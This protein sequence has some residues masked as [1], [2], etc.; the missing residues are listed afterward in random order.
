MIKNILEEADRLNDVL[1]ILNNII[2][3]LDSAPYPDYAFLDN[4][5]ITRWKV[6]GN[7]VKKA[8]NDVIQLIYDENHPVENDDD[9]LNLHEYV[10]SHT[11]DLLHNYAISI[12]HRVRPKIDIDDIRSWL[13]LNEL[14]LAICCHS[15]GTWRIP[16]GWRAVKICY[17]TGI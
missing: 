15:L 5:G 13:I 10:R 7:M 17:D 16:D 4:D 12:S 3:T 8:A 1:N 2:S 9:F 11:Y 14:I 6:N